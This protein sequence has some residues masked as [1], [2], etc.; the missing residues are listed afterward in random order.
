MKTHLILSALTNQQLEIITGSLLG[1]ASIWSNKNSKDIN[2]KFAK[3]QSCLDIFGIDKKDYMQ[4]HVDS[5]YPYSNN[6]IGY[7]ESVYKIL[8]HLHRNPINIKTSHIQSKSYIFTTHCHPVFNELGK[9]WY[10]NIDNEYVLRNN[11]KIKIIPSDIKLTPLSLCI[12]H[13]DDGYAD[14]TNGNIILCTNGFTW[15]ECEFLSERLKIDL[16][17]KSKVRAKDGSQIIYIPR[18]S[19]FDFIDLI[20]PY[21]QWECFK[22]KIDKTTYSKKPQ[23]GETHSQAKLTTEQIKE[24]VCL[25]KQGWTQKR[26]S[27]KFNTAKANISLIITGKRWS[28]ITGIE[29]KPIKPRI[30]DYIKNE[31]I[32]MNLSGMFQKNIANKLG[33]NQASVSRIIK[34]KT[35]QI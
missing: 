33:I 31:V 34:G 12:W 25:N 17:I 8:N 27:K 18:Q 2:F 9:K 20:K 16:N 11:R 4:W 1:D 28:H 22:H 14:R 26:I 13:M 23:I 29:H 19:Y 30:N 10:K 5:L 7:K 15:E 35:C 3:S 21:V 32:N 24:I 6:N